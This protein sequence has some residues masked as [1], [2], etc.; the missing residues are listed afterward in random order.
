MKDGIDEFCHIT[1]AYL[2]IA[3]SVGCPHVKAVHVIGQQIVNQPGHVT[4]THHAVCV[5][6][7]QRPDVLEKLPVTCR[8]ISLE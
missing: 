2:A 7:T 5:S 4:N 1:D 6:V 8:L 3:I